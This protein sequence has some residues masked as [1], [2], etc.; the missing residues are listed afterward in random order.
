MG[1]TFFED[2]AWHAAVAFSAEQWAR[3]P[4]GAAFETSMR[5]MFLQVRDAYPGCSVQIAAVTVEGA[6]TTFWSP[7]GV[8][9]VRRADGEAVALAR[10]DCCDLFGKMVSLVIPAHGGAPP[11]KTLLALD[12]AD[13]R[14]P[15]AAGIRAMREERYEVVATAAGVCAHV[16]RTSA[17][18]RYLL[19][20]KR[21][22]FGQED[23]YDKYIEK[24]TAAP[25]AGFDGFAMSERVADGFRREMID[26]ERQLY[27]LDDLVADG[28][29]FALRLTLGET[30]EKMRAS[31]LLAAASA[32]AAAWGRVHRADIRFGLRLA[33]HRK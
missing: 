6:T 14:P 30:A 16:P 32:D 10:T 19:E 4:A 23:E 17:L 11:R 13:V 27:F 1:R 3:D 2:V 31:P 20:H 28:A 18:G 25:Q 22:E 5:K 33:I 12:E 24:W 26:G 15:I 29:D 21:R 8:D 9:V 7:V